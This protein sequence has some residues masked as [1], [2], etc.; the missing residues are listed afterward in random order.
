MRLMVVMLI[1]ATMIIIIVDPRVH[2][3]GLHLVPPKHP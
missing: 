3:L 2:H 1:I